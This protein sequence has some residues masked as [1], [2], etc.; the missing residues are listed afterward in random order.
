[1]VMNSCS[2]SQHKSPSFKIRQVSHLHLINLF[3][4]KK[5]TVVY[6]QVTKKKKKFQMQSDITFHPLL[7]NPA[8]HF[9]A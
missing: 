8:Q 3:L 2:D 9:S 1:M 4:K 7:Y 6:K 5:P